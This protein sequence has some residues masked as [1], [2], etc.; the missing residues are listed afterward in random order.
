MYK[1]MKKVNRSCKEMQFMF[2]INCGEFKIYEQAMNQLSV[3]MGYCNE[4]YDSNGDKVSECIGIYAEHNTNKID[5]VY[6]ANI[7]KLTRILIGKKLSVYSNILVVP[8]KKLDMMLDLLLMNK[9]QITQIKLYNNLRYRVVPIIAGLGFKDSL[10]IFKFDITNVEKINNIEFKCKTSNDEYRTFKY[11]WISDELVPLGVTQ[12]YKELNN[13]IFS[14][15]IEDKEFKNNIIEVLDARLNS[16]LTVSIDNAR[17][18]SR[19]DIWADNETAKY[20]KSK[21]NKWI[22]GIVITSEIVTKVIKNKSIGNC[23]TSV[24]R[25][26]FVINDDIIDII[27]KELKEIVSTKFIGNKVGIALSSNDLMCINRLLGNISS[28]MSKGKIPYYFCK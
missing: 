28:N 25:C 2:N 3:R 24:K 5:I 13:R 27:I 4:A 19:Y 7:I 23:L 26:P 16:C 14:I 15:S 21:G 20:V 8:L 6:Q 10:A 17:Y 9:N 22:W 11:Q 12:G 18:N 1:L